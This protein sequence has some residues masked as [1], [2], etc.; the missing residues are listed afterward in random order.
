M[1]N[2]NVNRLNNAGQKYGFCAGIKYDSDKEG[3]KHK[4]TWHSIVRINGIEH[5]RGQGSNEKAAKEEAAGQALKVLEENNF[6]PN[7]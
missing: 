7:I 6:N 5:G 4:P 3:P 2:G 1:D